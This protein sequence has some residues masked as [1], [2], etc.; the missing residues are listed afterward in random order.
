MKANIFRYD[1]SCE[2]LDDASIGVFEIPASCIPHIG[3]TFSSEAIS[4]AVIR[5]TWHYDKDS[6]PTVDIFI[7][8]DKDETDDEDDIFLNSGSLIR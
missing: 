1:N 4:G 5:R 2:L 8:V 6:D 3:D 7:I